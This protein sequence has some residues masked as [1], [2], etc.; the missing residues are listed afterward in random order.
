MLSYN[1]AILRR[2]VIKKKQ[3]ECFESM[4]MKI[5]HNQKDERELL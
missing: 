3:A 1:D 5:K 4:M 2:L